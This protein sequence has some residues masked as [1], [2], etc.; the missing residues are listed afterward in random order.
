MNF[1]CRNAAFARLRVVEW[2]SAFMVP[3]NS[4]RSEPF[5]IFQGMALICADAGPMLTL[6]FIA[7]QTL[8][9]PGLAHGEEGNWFAS[10]TQGGGR[11]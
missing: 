10:Q 9:C 3:D 6:K 2:A 5:R 7:C 8:A 1:A 4:S 11:G